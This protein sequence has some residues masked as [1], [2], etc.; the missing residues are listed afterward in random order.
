M[1]SELACPDGGA[2]GVG[3]RHE[4]PSV[5]HQFHLVLD[6]RQGFPQSPRTSGRGAGQGDA[7]TLGAGYG[8]K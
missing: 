1:S 7:G 6:R 2:Q 8:A 5:Q 4:Q 3:R